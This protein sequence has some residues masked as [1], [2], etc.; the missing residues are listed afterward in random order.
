MRKQV[1]NT[2]AQLS[3]VRWDLVV[4]M[5]VLV[6]VLTLL[7]GLAVSVPL[8]VVFHGSQLDAQRAVGVSSLLVAVLVIGVTGGGAFRV[9]RTVKRGARLHGLLVGLIVA[10]LSCLLDVLFSRELRLVGLVLYALMVLAGWLGGV[11]SAH[12]RRP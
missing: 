8:L 12:W 1:V 6:Y 7:L 10:L 2:K 3:Q 11:L 9:A 4:K 5:A